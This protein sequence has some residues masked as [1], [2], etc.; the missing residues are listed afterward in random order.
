M[1]RHPNMKVYDQNGDKVGELTREI[2]PWND[3][4]EIDYEEVPAFEISNG[5]TETDTN[6]ENED[7]TEWIEPAPEQEFDLHFHTK[8]MIS[9]NFIKVDQWLIL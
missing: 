5:S 6:E 7:E 1:L 8:M 9:L 4:E 3:P 2:G